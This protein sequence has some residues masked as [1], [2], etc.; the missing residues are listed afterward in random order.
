M[1]CLLAAL[2]ITVQDDKPKELFVT[3]SDSNPLE[4][5]AFSGD[6]KRVIAAGREGSS[7]K[8][9]SV[10]DRKL[11]SQVKVEELKPFGIIAN[12]DGTRVVVLD[13]Q[14]LAL[15]ETEKTTPIKVLEEILNLVAEYLKVYSLAAFG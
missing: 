12:Q 15:I 10:E 1:I 3:D 4:A 8:T 2:L 13:F 7:V 5:L 14:K 6:G 11:V 9:W